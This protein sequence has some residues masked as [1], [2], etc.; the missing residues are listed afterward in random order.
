MEETPER[1]PVVSFL[2]TPDAY[3]QDYAK[4]VLN[5]AKKLE[6]KIKSLQQRKVDAGKEVKQ[7]LFASTYAQEV[8][9]HKVSSAVNIPFGH[10]VYEDLTPIDFDT[11]EFL[12][13]ME[14]KA[15]AAARPVKPRKKDP[16]PSLSLLE[17]AKT[18]EEEPCLKKVYHPPT[19]C[20]Q[21]VQP[22][23]S[24]RLYKHFAKLEG[25]DVS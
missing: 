7:Q 9:N 2:G 15:A 23:H 1:H 25:F 13:D 3:E 11:T 19:Y 22:G 8:F 24:Y 18:Y 21:G 16:E 10:R 12:K 4:P 6:S 17:P 20:L 5:S 14:R